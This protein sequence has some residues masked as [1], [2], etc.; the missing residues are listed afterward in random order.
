MALLRARRPRGTC[1]QIASFNL[2]TSQL[3]N[4]NATMAASV[5]NAHGHFL[6]AIFVM[7]VLNPGFV[8]LWDRHFEHLCV[9]PSAN[10]SSIASGDVTCC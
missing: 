8:F 9:P 6:K 2:S 1:K 3:Q 10:H 5:A 4:I 7:P